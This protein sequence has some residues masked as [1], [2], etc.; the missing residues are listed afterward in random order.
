MVAKPATA[1][2]INPIKV[3][4]F[5]PVFHSISNQVTAAKEAAV[6]VFKKEETVIELTA[7]SLPALNPYQPNHNNAVPIATNGI[8][9]GSCVFCRRPTKYTDAKAAKPAVA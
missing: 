9:L 7:N 8:L 5:F 2:V 1:P 3:G 6:S 4:F